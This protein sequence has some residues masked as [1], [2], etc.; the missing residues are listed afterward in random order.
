MKRFRIEEEE[1][2]RH[3][4]KLEKKNLTELKEKKV[5]LN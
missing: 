4:G 5:L 2:E 3:I 1:I